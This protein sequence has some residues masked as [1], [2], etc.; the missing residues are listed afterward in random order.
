MNEKYLVIDEIINGDRFETV[1]DS[2][3][4]ANRE[5]AYQWEHLTARERKQ[6]HLYAVVVKR[7]WL[8][9]DAIDEDDGSIEWAMFDQADA[10]PGAFDSEEV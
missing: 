5:A 10:F 1:C 6:R 7:E 2:A 8:S 3:E 4:E 9:E